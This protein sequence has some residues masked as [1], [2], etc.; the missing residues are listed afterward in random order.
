MFVGHP[1]NIFCWR[2]KKK[3][4]V[5]GFCFLYPLIVIRFSCFGF[6][7]PTVCNFNL[8]YAYKGLISFIDLSFV[9]VKTTFTLCRAFALFTLTI[10]AHALSAQDAHFSQYLNSPMNLGPGMTGIFGGDTRFTANYRNQWAAIPVPYTTFSGVVE[11]KFYLEKLRYDRYLTGGLVLN[12]DRQGSLNLT[13]I[14]VGVPVSYTIPLM[15]KGGLAANNFLTLGVVPMFGQRSFGTKNVSF[16]AQF[17]DRMYDP[18]ASF[19]E[20]QLLDNTNLNYFDFSAGLNYRW[21][22]KMYRSKV[23]L[24]AGWHHINRPRHDFFPGDDKLRL[25]RRL[26]LYSSLLFQVASKV[27]LVGQGM[28]QTQG[29]YREFAFGAGARVHLN[30]LPYREMALQF[31]ANYRQTNNDAIIPHLEFHWRTWTVGLSYDINISAARTLTDGRGGPE[32][33]LI[34]RLYKVKPL[35]K[36]KSCPII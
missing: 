2:N 8:L 3:P 32:L 16:D 13:S 20:P 5:W 10:F 30:Q 21:Q 17:V 24:G 15:P 1:A 14:Q 18:S 28:Y 12:Y 33:A 29:S 6:Y 19:Q 9:F 27:D 11:N 25:Q 7:S 26:A 35:S 36:F 31:G 4:Y 34:Y 23:D 22:A